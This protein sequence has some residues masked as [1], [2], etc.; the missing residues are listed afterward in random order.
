[1]KLASRLHMSKQECMEQTSGLDFHEWLI[2][3]D[4][5]EL[6]EVTK[7][8]HYLAQIA[9]EIRRSI[10]P[11]QSLSLDT[12]ILKF[13]RAS[14]GTDLE[15]MTDEEIENHKKLAAARSKM[16]WSALTGTTIPIDYPTE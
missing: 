9:L 16:Y 12:F 2:Y 15:S 11:K 14:N 10:N 8:Q 6:E 4:K 7:D 1:M 5:I 13:D 3:L